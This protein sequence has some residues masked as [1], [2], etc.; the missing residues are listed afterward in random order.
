MHIL[1]PFLLQAF[2]PFS[3]SLPLRVSVLLKYSS[4][5]PAPTLFAVSSPSPALPPPMLSA[6]RHTVFLLRQEMDTQASHGSVPLFSA[7]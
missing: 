4:L 3:D 1:F 7:G 6:L 5:L 2:L